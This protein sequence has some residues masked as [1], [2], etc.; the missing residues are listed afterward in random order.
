MDNWVWALLLLVLAIAIGF[1]ELFV[2]SGGSLT[3]LAILVFIGSVVFAFLQGTAFGSIF[4]VL[5][6]VG[7]PLSIWYLL[8][9]WQTTPLSRHILL[10]P[11]DDPALWR[12][13]T[14][15]KYKTLIGKMGIA[16]SV[17]TP[18][19]QIEIDGKCYDAISEGMAIDPKTTI[20]VVQ[21][22]GVHITIRAVQNVSG[23]SSNTSQTT[24]MEETCE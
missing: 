18:A 21:V 5:V 4:V 2:P 22:D 11:A 17:M 23:H 1:I 13:E 6:M 12:D 15:E 19:G 10:D 3:A 24:K 16:K 7:V 9:I 20:V 14:V 8:K